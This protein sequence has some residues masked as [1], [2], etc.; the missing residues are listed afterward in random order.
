MA[1]FDH[2]NASI[3][4]ETNGTGEPVIALHGL[5]ENTL[6]WKLTGVSEYLEKH[7][8]VTLT[9]MRG[10]GRTRVNDDPPGYDAETVMDDI[11]ALADHLGIDRFHLISHSTGGF[12][13][14][15][16]AMKNS[17][18]LLSLTLTGTGSA[19]QPFP[20]PDGS[21]HE[22]FAKSFEKRTWEQMLGLIKV[23]PFPFFSGIAE[24]DNNESMW[25]VAYEMM[26][27]GN[28]TEI[29]RFIRSFYTD[30]DPMPDGLKQ[31]GCPTLILVGD[32][33][34]LFLAPSDLMH[35]HIRDSK[36]KIIEN[37]GHMLAIEKPLETG[38]LI[39]DFLLSTQ[40]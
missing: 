40:A 16:Y 39:R 8:T 30:P 22:R 1:F 25:Q 31:I 2:N 38:E 10:H 13:A 20:D 24:S 36:L 27:Q 37:T 18:R 4:Y 29:G 17:D 23:M 11:P 7:F 15:R 12:A 33:D 34:H 26:K 32:K 21:F 28:R 14:V 3:Y 6:Y 9:D 35:R 19:T 5:T